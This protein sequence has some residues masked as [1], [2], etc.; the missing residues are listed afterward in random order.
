MNLNTGIFVELKGIIEAWKT[1]E[2]I[3]FLPPQTVQQA[4]AIQYHW[5]QNPTSRAMPTLRVLSSLYGMMRFDGNRKYKD[6]D[7][8]DFLTAASAL[9]IAEAFFTDRRL[10]ALLAEPTLSL[11]SFSKCVV[12]SGF[13]E[14]TKYIEPTPPTPAAAE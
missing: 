14:M 2:G 11:K 7:Q 3:P 4:A 6:G 10:A 9:P 8:A 5:H 13:E 12:V 1:G